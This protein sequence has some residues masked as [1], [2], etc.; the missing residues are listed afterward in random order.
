MLV[1]GYLLDSTPKGKKIY[2]RHEIL[3]VIKKEEMLKNV[4]RLG[5]GLGAE[6]SLILEER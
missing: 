3:P 6:S 1:T 2:S 4:R 5:A